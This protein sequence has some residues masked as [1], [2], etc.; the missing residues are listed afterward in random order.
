MEMTQLDVSSPLTSAGIVPPAAAESLG[1]DI[2]EAS[3]TRSTG[4]GAPS[5]SEVSS[6]E[7]DKVTDPGAQGASPSI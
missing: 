6:Q 2:D 1:D 5:E 3:P 7:W 4:S